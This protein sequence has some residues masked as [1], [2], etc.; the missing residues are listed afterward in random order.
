MYRNENR[1][2][3]AEEGSSVAQKEEKPA[4]SRR[5]FVGRLAAGAAVTL[6]AGV[7]T[8]KALTPR[9]ESVGGAKATDL[10][11]TAPQSAQFPHDVVQG[12]EAGGPPPWELLH[13]LGAGASVG[14]GWKIA[15]LTGITNGSCVLTLENAKG[16]T[17][18]V[19][20]CRNDGSPQGLV[21]THRL[22]LMVMNGGQ[23]DLPTDETLAQAIAEVAHV[24][25]A[26][27]GRNGALVN[28]LLPH[29]ERVEQF[30]SAAKLR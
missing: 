3:Q 16:R 29:A 24:L 5:V 19:H 1:D 9:T 25:A 7:G 18:R 23:G 20:L 26:N 15:E 2:H 12:A 14:S 17:Q 28:A 22:D 10:P 11:T 27:E 13:P 21:Y 6:A 4:L 30:A 8:A